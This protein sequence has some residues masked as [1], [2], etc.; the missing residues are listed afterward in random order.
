MSTNPLNLDLGIHADNI[1]NDL[2]LNTSNITI[3]IKT[4]LVKTEGN[5][6]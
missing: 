5:E 1:Q 6:I 3:P 2:N 4:E